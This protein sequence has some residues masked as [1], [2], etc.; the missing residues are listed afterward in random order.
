MLA[1]LT[2]IFGF[3]IFIL[4]LNK[5][6]LLFVNITSLLIVAAI[7]LGVGYG[8]ALFVISIGKQLLI[9]V[10]VLVMITIIFATF[11]MKGNSK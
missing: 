4:I 3:M 1:A 6:N 9:I 7:S 2:I 11:M 5:G 8:I 10:G